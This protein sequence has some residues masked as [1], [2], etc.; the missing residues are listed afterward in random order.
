MV[1]EMP[2]KWHEMTKI[3]MHNWP[4]EPV[5]QCLNEFVG[6]W[7]NESMNEQTTWN[8]TNWNEMKGEERKGNEGMI[9]W[10]KK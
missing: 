2:T 10:M 6:Q 5:N 8:E 9:K 4:S 7:I 1:V 3:F